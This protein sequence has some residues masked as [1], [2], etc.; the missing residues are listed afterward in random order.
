MGAMPT[1]GEWISRRREELG[2]S[3]SAAARAAKIARSTW[4]NW[5]KDNKTPERFNYVRIETILDWEPGSVQA[6]LEGRDPVARRK[7]HGPPPIPEGVLIDPADW[8]AMTPDER[9]AF[10]RIVTG[11]RRRRQQSSRGA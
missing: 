1:L 5:E 10:V 4:V 7:D 9:T 3:Q 11:V 2:T 6:V 8:A